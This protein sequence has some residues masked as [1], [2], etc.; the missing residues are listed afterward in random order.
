MFTI[1]PG[2]QARKFL[3]TAEAGLRE[4]ILNKLRGLSADSEPRGAI[5]VIGEGNVYRI[6]VGDYRIL[7]EIYHTE[8]KIILVKIDKR[9]RVYD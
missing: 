7:Y 1:I 6:R 8:K 2:P 4:R 5:K 9:S 3:R